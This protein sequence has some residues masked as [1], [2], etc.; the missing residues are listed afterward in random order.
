MEAA[1]I[2]LVSYM[3]RLLF[4]T[5]LSTM[6]CI[7]P[8][9]TFTVCFLHRCRVSF[10]WFEGFSFPQRID[11]QGIIW[12]MLSFQ[13]TNTV[14]KKV[15]LFPTLQ[16]LLSKA[17]IQRNCLKQEYK[18]IIHSTQDWESLLSMNQNRQTRST[19]SDVCSA[20]NKQMQTQTNSIMF[21]V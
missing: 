16:C 12:Q 15:A 19:H 17:L 20:G 5:Q 2:L 1:E 10:F 13:P 4:V 18:Q 21:E 14:K 9:I 6:Y 8:V 7:G 3:R 11:F